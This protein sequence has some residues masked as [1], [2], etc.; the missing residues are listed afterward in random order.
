MEIV[1]N[2]VRT[3]LGEIERVLTARTVVGDPITVEGIT[4]IPVI[5]VGFAFG[6][7]GGEG[8][9]ELKARSEGTG[10]GT[11]GGAWV[12]PRA[13]IVIDKEGVRIEP[14]GGRMSFAMEKMGET[15]PRMVEMFMKK[16]EDR[17]KEG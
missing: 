6:A 7:G 9:S 3:S 10:S 17:K 8:K 2:L 14:I 1:E 11:G 15:I 4:L 16:R 13:V 12:K 5:S